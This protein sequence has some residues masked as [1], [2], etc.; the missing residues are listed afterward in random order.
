E[1]GADN[2]GLGFGFHKGGQSRGERKKSSRQPMLLEISGLGDTLPALNLF[3]VEPINRPTVSRP[4][5]NFRSFVVMPA[6][7]IDC[8]KV[9]DYAAL[10]DGLRILVARFRGRSMPA[11]RYHVMGMK[12]QTITI[13]LRFLLPLCI[14]LNMT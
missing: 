1:K 11:S 2:G 4:Q 13:A 5:E 7:R 14:G 3:Y 6:G 8:F 9:E 12:T 10:V